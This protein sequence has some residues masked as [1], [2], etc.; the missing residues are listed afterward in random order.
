MNELSVNRRARFDYEI[1][2]TYEAGIELWG[3]E[4]KSAKAGRMQIAGSF[5]VIKNNEAWLLSATIP[6]Y[7]AKNA[8]EDFDP[9]RSRR[10]L[11]RKSEIT[12]LIGKTAQ[13]GLTLIP[14]RVYTKR[15]LIKLAIGLGRHQKKKDK[16]EVIKKR[17]ASREIEKIKK[18][19]G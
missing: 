2:E 14:L 6:Q 1:L 10:L 11:L 17:E 9:T 15:H 8:P 7:Q 3:F 18:S 4:V 16:R 12:E 5:A 13:K 19:W